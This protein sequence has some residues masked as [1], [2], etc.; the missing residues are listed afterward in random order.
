[1]ALPSEYFAMPTYEYE[2]QKC[3]H[4]FE[5][6]Q[7]IKAAPLTACPRNGCDGQVRRLI[8]A[9]GGLLF[10]GSGFYTTDYRSDG[11]RQAAKAEKGS[12]SPP[13]AAESKG[14]GKADTTPSTAKKE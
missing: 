13:P 9:G 11:Y 3:G 6:F 5:K 12:S 1:M 8:S 7:S 10:R 2:C 4:R 14:S